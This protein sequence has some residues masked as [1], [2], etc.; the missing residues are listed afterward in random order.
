VSFNQLLSYEL[1]ILTIY[2]FC[3]LFTKC[4]YGDQTKDEMGGA[5]SMHAY[6]IFVVKPERKRPLGKFGCRWEGNSRMDVW[7]IGWEGAN[8]VYRAQDREQWR[9]LVNIVMNLWVP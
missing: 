8:W 4:Y 3:V 6:E 2:A 7:K 5:F 9:D 1:I